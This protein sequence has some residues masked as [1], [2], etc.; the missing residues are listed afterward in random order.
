MTTIDDIRERLTEIRPPGVRG[1]VVALGMVQGIDAHNGAVTIHL[2][3]GSM[4]APSLNATIADIRRAVGALEGITA[5]DVRVKTT[6]QQ[7]QS[8]MGELGPIPGVRDIVAVSSAKGGVGKSTVAANLALAIQQRGRSV[9][10][11]DCDV[12]GPSM[13]LML[14]ISSRPRMDDNKRILPIEKYGL[15]VMSLG[16]FLDDSSPVIWRGPLVMG[17]VRQFL[18]D[19]EWGDLD[20]LIVDLPP[21]TGDAQLTLV[22]QVPLAG[23]VIVTT[24][25]DVALLDVQ[26]GIAMFQEVNTPVLGVVENM[27]YYVCPKCQRREDVFG[28]GGG[29]RI[30][31][32]FAV[33]LLGSIPLFSAIRES[34]DAGKPLVIEQP[35]HPAAAIFRDI[36]GQ[37]I[38]ADE[39]QHAEPTA[40]RIVG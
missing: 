33:P 25:Q 10:L 3:P 23:G 5:V 34:G 19:V 12:Y 1:D 38:D 6:A 40:P 30:A 11:L 31:A 26:R 32:R 22:Q 29:D 13:P 18:K 24:P 27:S 8:P 15:R 2:A 20:M 36:A 9:G 17:L 4:P 35:T 28:S 14:G 16:F 37:V 7:A 39:A 21:G